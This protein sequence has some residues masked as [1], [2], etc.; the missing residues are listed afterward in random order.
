MSKQFTPTPAAK[1]NRFCP[2]CKEKQSHV[3]KDICHACRNETGGFWVSGA[4]S[5]PRKTGDWATAHERN[6]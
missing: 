2:R 1:P 5:A 4:K 6:H 3:V